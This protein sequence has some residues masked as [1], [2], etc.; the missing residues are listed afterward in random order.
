[1]ATDLRRG[2]LAD[3]DWAGGESHTLAETDHDT[4]GD[5]DAELV[6]GGEGLHERRDNGDEA[7]DGH[8]PSTSEVIGLC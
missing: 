7:A 4:A 5:E 8:A 3:V 1:M 6:V 2:D